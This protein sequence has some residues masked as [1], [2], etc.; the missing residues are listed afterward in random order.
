MIGTPVTPTTKPGA[1]LLIARAGQVVHVG[2]F[3]GG[4]GSED[5]WGRVTVEMRGSSARF[6]ASGGYVWRVIR[7]AVARRIAEALMFEANALDQ[8]ARCRNRANEIAKLL[9]ER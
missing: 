2:A 7:P 8:A 9:E 4:D 3:L 5:P 6:E 1:M